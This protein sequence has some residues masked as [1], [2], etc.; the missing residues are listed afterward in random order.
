MM[1]KRILVVDDS[2]TSRGVL[3]KYLATQRDL[4]VCGEAVNG[5]DAIEKARKLK[6]DLVLLDVAMPGTNGIVVASVLK[7][8]MPGI[9]IILFT[10]YTEALA[11][12]FPCGG[13][14]VDAVISKG[15]GMQKLADC[16]Q[17]LLY[18]YTG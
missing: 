5:E 16:V 6:P 7:E 9:R 11:R 8:M 3:A 12:A 1:S 18:S 17:S 13:L 15:D 2:D 10:M 14:A 4:D